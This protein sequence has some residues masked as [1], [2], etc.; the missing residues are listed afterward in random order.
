VGEIRRLT[1]MAMTVS[2][3]VLS[4]ANV[5]AVVLS[6]QPPGARQQ[7]IETHRSHGPEQPWVF[8]SLRF[9]FSKAAGPGVCDLPNLR[10]PSGGSPQPSC[11]LRSRAAFLPKDPPAGAPGPYLADP[12]ADAAVIRSCGCS[13]SGKSRFNGP[14]GCAHPNMDLPA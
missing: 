3:Q 11:A 9:A 13:P 4:F 6:F 5:T 10:V 14:T 2:G 7:A 1:Q 8:L 12:K